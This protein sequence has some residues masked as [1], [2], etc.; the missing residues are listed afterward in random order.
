MHLWVILQA[1]EYAMRMSHDQKLTYVN[2]FDHPWILAGQGT[3]GL[4][5]LEQVPDVDAVVR[6][7]MI[8][9]PRTYMP[10]TEST[11]SSLKAET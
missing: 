1:K 3:C 2:G 10:G 11:I 8:Q 5:I 4:E 9:V 6:V 7:P